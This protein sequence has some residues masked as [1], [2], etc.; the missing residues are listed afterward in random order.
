MGLTIPV[1]GDG[2]ALWYGAIVLLVLSWV[3]FTMRMG[4]RVWR[5]AFGWDDGFMLIGIVCVQNLRRA[6]SSLTSPLRYFSRSLQRCA[7]CAPTTARVN[8]PVMCL[9]SRWQ[10][11]SRYV[12]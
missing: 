7:L 5:K 12:L 10:R 8:L 4:V 9:R 3:T 2:V 1:A 11:A 6:N